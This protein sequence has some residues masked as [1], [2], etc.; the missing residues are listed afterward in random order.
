MSNVE[1]DIVFLRVLRGEKGTLLWIL[2]VLRLVEN[3]GSVKDASLTIL[4]GFSF[5]R[6]QV[7]VF[8]L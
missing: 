4:Q 2:L 6:M 5:C 1:I 3:G 8:F 7:C